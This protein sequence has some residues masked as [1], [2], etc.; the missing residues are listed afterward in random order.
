[1]LN[2]IQNAQR[3]VM[4]IFWTTR[5]GLPRRFMPVCFDNRGEDRVTNRCRLNISHVKTVGVG[6]SLGVKFASADDA[7][8]LCAAG[9]CH[10]IRRGDSDIKV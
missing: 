1:M 4:I 2:P 8:F 7:V 10:R 5:K 6:D 9:F 3:E